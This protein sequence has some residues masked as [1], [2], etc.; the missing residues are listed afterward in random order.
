MPTDPSPHLF[1]FDLDRAIRVQ[2]IAKL[3]ESPMLPLRKS[4]GPQESG[5]YALDWKRKLP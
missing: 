2:L 5:V 1:V 4:L 3:R